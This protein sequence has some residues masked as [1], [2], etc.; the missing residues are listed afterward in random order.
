E[1]PANNGR[2]AGPSPVPLAL[3]RAPRFADVDSP[4]RLLKRQVPAWTISGGIPLVLMALFLVLA[5]PN[6]A[7][8]AP[9]PETQLLETR[10]EDAPQQKWNFENTDVGLDPS[11]ETNYNVERIENVSVPGKVQLDGPVGIDGAPDGAPQTVPPPPGFGGG[12]GGGL[13]SD[14]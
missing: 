11:K 12:Q 1:T 14:V 10:V 2:P 3:V 6:S 5:G 8:E 13:K 4:D 9:P 7:A